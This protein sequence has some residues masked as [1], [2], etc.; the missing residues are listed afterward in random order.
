MLIALWLVLGLVLG[1][2]FVFFARACGERNVFA[3]GI[4]VAALIYVAFAL[5][6]SA[7][8]R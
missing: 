5:F 3:Y 2:A 4:V 6:G 1:T 7:D 8:S